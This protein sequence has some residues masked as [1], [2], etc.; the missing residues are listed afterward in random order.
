MTGDDERD[1]AA[2][3]G[4]LAEAA[5]LVAEGSELQHLAGELVA[6]LGQVLPVDRCTLA[7]LEDEAEQYRLLTLIGED[8]SS[9]VEFPADRG[10]AGM[11][12]RSRQPHLIADLGAARAEI[13]QPADSHLW[14]GSLASVLSLPLQASGRVLGALTLGAAAPRAYSEDDVQWATSVAAYLALAVERELERAQLRRLRDE[15]ARLGSFPELNPAEIIELDLS[16]QVHYLNPAAAERFPEC[17][18]DGLQSPLFVDV[19]PVVEALREAGEF[20]HMREL[21]IDGAWYQQVLHLVPNSDRIRSF[22]MDITERKRVEETLQQQNE[23][24][25]ALHATTLGMLSRLDRDE[26][27]QDIVMRAGQ[28]LQTRHGFIFLLEPA[29][30]E[31]EQKVGVGIFAETIGLRLKRGEGAAGRVWV[32]GKPTVVADYD[33][34]APRTQAYDGNQ[35]RALAAVPLRSGNEVVGAIGMA[36]G[37]GSQR[38]FGNAE[39]ELLNRFAQLASLALDN[40]QLFVRT[41]QQ[42]RRLAL[43]SQMGEELSRTTDLQEILEIAAAKTTSIFPEEQIRVTLHDSSRQEGTALRLEG[44]SGPGTEQAF[45][46]DCFVARFVAGLAP[47]IDVSADDPCAGMSVPLQSGGQSIGSL[48]VVCDRPYAFTDDDRNILQQL[49]SL[50]S[51]AIE[52]A[53]LFEENLRG[54]AEAEE[55]AWRLASLNKMG[56]QLSLAGDTDEILQ[57]VTR[58]VPQILSADHFSAALLAANGHGGDGQDAME[59]L[60]LRG[61]GSALPI[62]QRVPQD[63]TLVGQAVREK[64]VIRLADIRESDAADAQVLARQGL[65]AGMTAP[66]LVGE[67]AIGTL[68]VASEQAGV[69]EARDE[70]L[71]LQIASFLA[72]TMENVRLFREAEAAR[73]AA[74]AANEAKSAFLANMS[75]E[76]RTPMNAIIGMTSLLRD[77][78]LNPEQRDFTETIRQSGEAL[79]T[80][81][82]DILDFSKIEADRLELESQAFDL[83]EC[84]ESS[85]DLLAPSAAEKGL[86]LAYLVAL[87]TP[88]A[89]VGDV[90]RLRQILVNLLSNAV[91]FTEQGEVV[92]SVSSERLSS[93]AAD[94]DRDMHLLRFAIRDTGIG[95]PEDRRDRLFRSFSQVDASTT[96]RYGGTGLGLAISRR[97]SEMMGGSMWLESELGQGSTF[98]FTIEAPAAPAPARAYLDEVQPALQGKRV[99]I[100]DDNATNRRILTHQVRRWQMHPQATA[101]PLEA[102]DWL[103]DGAAFDVG[104]LDMQM[105]EM[106]GLALARAIR[107]LPAPAASLPLVMLTSLGRGEVKETMDEFAAFLTK[108]IKPS[109][110]FDALVSMFTGQPVRVGRRP[111]KDGQRFDA[112]IGE[113]WPLRILLAEDNATNQ[114]LALRILARLGYQADLAANGLE[115]LKALERQVYDVVLMDVQ[116]PE[117]DGLEAT[118]R[119]RRELTGERQPRVIA[120]TANAMQGDREMCLAA[121]MDDYVSKP[122]RIEELIE[123]LS[124]SRPLD[125]DHG[126]EGAGKSS[127]TTS[128][129]G[130]PVGDRTRQKATA[131]TLDRTA[132]PEVAVL[133]PA[134]LQDLLSVLGGEFTYMEEVIDSFLEDAPQLLAELRRFVDEG[135]AEGASRMAHSLKSNGADFGATT[136]AELCK[137]LETR[138]RVG[139]LE[140]AADLAAAIT[141]E[142]DRV[143]AA[144]VALRYEGRIP[145]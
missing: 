39:V 123:A 21:K 140:G 17:C 88:E 105:P 40:A 4:L 9:E 126:A 100:V 81:I 118:R 128:S 33:N 27:L 142:Y 62:G 52:N 91:K 32:S 80:I 115:A 63:G 101:S 139:S 45:D 89:V 134:P 55:Q 7:L 24:L 8:V 131:P 58:F 114:K 116:M 70:S 34:W 14:D 102:L 69:Y 49:A 41:Q 117:M 136:F 18:K 119:L 44:Q 95:I 46:G 83:R 103:G 75:H 104:I 76:I 51:S 98:H 31:L 68:N 122:I 96:R 94:V 54:L 77:T 22:V 84:I 82:N 28:L 67:R 64:R 124:K 138:G 50:L 93:P 3:L 60:A 99:L 106:D 25:A 113:Q 6:R 71:F 90:T 74:E 127:D 48:E 59:V 112:A 97:L 65:R 109:S 108:P 57:V 85:L 29:A 111:A 30:E 66:L 13:R 72:T 56:Q 10:L 135:N 5:V 12:M 19:W 38:I 2:R 92:L 20:S 73:E 61:E 125:A 141:A 132:A 53:R 129:G 43:L 47:G 130:N 35:I 145:A 26:L 107:K 15:V 144:L 11:V 23:Y 42:A 143:A 120:M 137:E 78:I 16:G 110:L 133:D 36:Y 37:A 121:G 1:R 86:D 79:L 87:D